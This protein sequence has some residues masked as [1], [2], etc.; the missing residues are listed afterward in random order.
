MLLLFF[1]LLIL[2]QN[3]PLQ[4]SEQSLKSIYD[5]LYTIKISNGKQS[6]TIKN[7]TMEA[8]L[9]IITKSPKSSSQIKKRIKKNNLYKISYIINSKTDRKIV[10]EFYPT[11]EFYPTRQSSVDRKTVK[12]AE[13]QCFYNILINNKAYYRKTSEEIVGLL[14]FDAVLQK[15]LLKHLQKTQSLSYSCKDS[16]GKCLKL[17]ITPSKNHFLKPYK[18]NRNNTMN[19][20]S[21][22]F[23][24]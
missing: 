22:A 7:L 21:L 8:A 14:K 20:N 5:R 17:N 1:A 18:F 9:K 10:I 3:T 11:D 2:I 4:G 23:I 24:T 6:K 15:K 19:A 12:K 13:K 16:N